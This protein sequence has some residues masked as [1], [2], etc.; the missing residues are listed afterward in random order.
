[1]TSRDIIIASL[2]F[3]R[4]HLVNDI[5]DKGN[6][7]EKTKCIEKIDYLIDFL[8]KSDIDFLSK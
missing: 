2:E 1:M 5:I 3:F 4:I 7:P 6:N 8:S